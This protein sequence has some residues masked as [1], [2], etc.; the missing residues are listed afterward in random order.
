MNAFLKAIQ[1]R[2][3][4]SNEDFA[5]KVVIRYRTQQPMSKFAKNLFE[6]EDV[7]SLNARLNKARTKAFNE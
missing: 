1:L 3:T 2:W 5:T 4:S 7:R 6:N